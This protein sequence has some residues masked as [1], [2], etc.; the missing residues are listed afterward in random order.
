MTLLD[1]FAK[2]R[3][4]TISFV[5]SV[6]P[7]AF[8]HGTT[9]LPLDGLSWNLIFEYFFENLLRKFKIHYNL[10]TTTGTLHEDRYTF[11]IISRS[12]LLRMKNVS[13]KSCRENQNTFYL[14]PLFFSENRAV[15]EIMNLIL[16]CIVLLSHSFILLGSIFLSMYMWFYSCL[17]M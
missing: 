9:R 16:I 13:D 17:I 1:G 12:F 10:T 2:L 3:N 6:C 7:S 11:F 15:Y 4:A 5:M 8:P 14:Q